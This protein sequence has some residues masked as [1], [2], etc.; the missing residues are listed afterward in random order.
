[1][2]HRAVNGLLWARQALRAPH[3]EPKRKRG[4]KA[5]GI[6]YEKALAK[7]LPSARHG[8]WFEFCDTN[9]RGYCQPDFLIELLGAPFVLEAKLR[10]VS[11]G[12][13]QIMEL[14]QPVLREVLGQPVFGIAIV[15]TLS[16]LPPRVVAWHNLREAALAAL[17]G[18]P[19][20]L[21]WREGYPLVLGPHS[22]PPSPQGLDTSYPAP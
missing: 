4:A 8:L 15:R 18:T 21:L 14:Y 20:V 2:S 17:R 11:G 22:P 10:D 12:L 7:A 1:M 5:I 19:S 3:R 16:V 6:R 9:G 13:A